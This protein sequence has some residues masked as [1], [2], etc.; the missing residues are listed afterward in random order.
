MWVFPGSVKDL[1]HWWVGAKFNKV[2][3]KMWKLVP[4]AFIW[5]IWK[6]KN[7]CL[8]NGKSVH[9][10]ELSELVTVGLALWSKS[11][12]KGIQYSVH[13]IVTNLHKIKACV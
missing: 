3:L 6:A 7:E 9:W 1:L 11:N 5:S 2:V 8:F 10:N 4:L 12:I 13:D